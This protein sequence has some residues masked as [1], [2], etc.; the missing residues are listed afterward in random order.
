MDME[1][2][3]QTEEIS[4]SSAN[5]DLLQIWSHR[6]VG[7]SASRTQA[8]VILI[9][10]AFF[11]LLPQ[12]L[13]PFRFMGAIR[14]PMLVSLIAIAVWIPSIS[15]GWSRATKLVAIF[16][17]IEAARGIIGMY[18]DPSDVI[19]RN[20]FWQFQTWK[21][22]ATKIC[23]ITFPLVVFMRSGRNLGAVFRWS[24]LIGGFLGFW[25]MTHSG[26]GPGGYLG[27]ENDI[28]LVLVM[29][30]PFA[31]IGIGLARSFLFKLLSVGSG[32]LIFA[33][34]VATDSRGGFLGLV[35]VVV[36]IFLR[37]RN[38]AKMIMLGI[39]CCL[40]V[41]PF[42]PD[43]YWKEMSTIHSDVE[44]ETG[45][46][47]A[48]K[49]M[50][51]VA[52][53]IWL[54]PR[55]FVFGVGLSNTPYW[56][57]DYE[58]ADQTLKGRSFSG[59]VVHSL[60]FQLL[61]ELGLMGIILIGG[62]VGFSIYGNRR[63][64]IK[65]HQYE[66]RMQ[67]IVRRSL[68]SPEKAGLEKE[69]SQLETNDQ[70]EE[71][72]VV[73]NADVDRLL[74]A[75]NSEL[76]AVQTYFMIINASWIGVLVAGIGISVLYYPPIWFLIGLSTATQSYWFSLLKPCEMLANNIMATKSTKYS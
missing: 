65:G 52:T 37:S 70:G 26:R 73:E 56:F 34:I 21:D 62:A 40:F 69:A 36:Y 44:Q 63:C 39:V 16:L 68:K 28:C 1:S 50:W 33:G 18:M 14:L 66:K 10:I 47:Q 71:V 15:Q 67:L 25:A 64:L 58:D 29:F 41:L 20:D 17:L 2:T 30:L 59:R 53:R 31:V 24:T 48:R 27:D 3:G 55:N 12:Y 5:A 72:E 49:E 54:D 76:K 9:N 4:E 74:F 32:L 46:I 61:P 8:L 11:F 45:T 57:K 38:K 13:P 43:E 60:Y 42:V 7:T 75:A 22:L 51:K 35:G 6:L 19:V 23:S